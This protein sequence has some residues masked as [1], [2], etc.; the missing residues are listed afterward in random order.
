MCNHRQQNNPGCNAELLSCGM[1]SLWPGV[2]LTKT[3]KAGTQICY[4]YGRG[5]FKSV[6]GKDLRTYRGFDFW[7]VQHYHAQPLKKV[8]NIPPPNWPSAPVNQPPSA[9]QLQREE[10]MVM[11]RKRQAPYSASGSKASG[12]AAL[13]ALLAV[14]LA[15]Q[16]ESWAHWL[17]LALA[18]A[19]HAHVPA[20]M[21]PRLRTS[22]AF[23]TSA[24]LAGGSSTH[25]PMDAGCIEHPAITAGIEQ[26]SIPAEIAPI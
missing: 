15:T 21:R 22:S 11:A 25:S 12:H 24:P 5:Y 13:A 9:G 26:S 18:D 19:K 7:G 10:S 20:A 16:V 2:V 14:S 8:T 4:Y 3:V 6:L 1:G 17:S 23:R